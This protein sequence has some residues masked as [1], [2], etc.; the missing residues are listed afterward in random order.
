MAERTVRVRCYLPHGEKPSMGPG[1]CWACGERPE[2]PPGVVR[3]ILADPLVEAQLR[4]AEAEWDNYRRYPPVAGVSRSGV[5][6]RNETWLTMKRLI[7]NTA[8]QT[9]TAAPE[10]LPVNENLV[11]RQDWRQARGVGQTTSKIS[12]EEA[13]RAVRDA[14]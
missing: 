13:I 5:A 4:Y 8:P 2:N 12:P 14:E 3:C 11:E 1:F 9:G 10:A 6:V 7:E